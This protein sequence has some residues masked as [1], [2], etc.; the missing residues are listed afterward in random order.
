L[1]PFC[2]Q[3]LSEISGFRR[4]VGEIGALLG[5]YTVSSDNLLL[6]FRAI[7]KGKVF[8]KKGIL[9]LLILED[10][11]DGLSRNVGKNLPL[12]AA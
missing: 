1:L 2:I 6:T 7:F 5:N 11:T 10:G 8:K 3:Q 4:A 12:L 9:G